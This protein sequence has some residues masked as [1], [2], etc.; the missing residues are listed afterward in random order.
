MRA[1]SSRLTNYEMYIKLRTFEIETGF[2]RQLM[3]G[4]NGWDS[5]EPE[6]ETTL[7]FSW[8]P[9]SQVDKIEFGI[10]W[11]CLE[12]PLLASLACIGIIWDCF[13]ILRGRKR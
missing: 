11:T 1:K 6:H 3:D 5:K 10:V 8:Q 7:V 9:S 13:I 2:N 4:L 12:I